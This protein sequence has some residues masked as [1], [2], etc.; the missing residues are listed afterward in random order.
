MSYS[1]MP[2]PACD[3]EAILHHTAYRSWLLTCP[4]CDLQGAGNTAEAAC[5]WLKR[6]AA[7]RETQ[8]IQKP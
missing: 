6:Q 2:C 4:H 1:V 5:A 3:K 7:A 8:R